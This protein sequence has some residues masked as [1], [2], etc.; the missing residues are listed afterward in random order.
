EYLTFESHQTGEMRV[1]RRKKRLVTSQRASPELHLRARRLGRAGKKGK[2]H[3]QEK[4]HQENRRELHRHAGP[5]RSDLCVAAERR[6]HR[7]G[8]KN[9]TAGF[10]PE[11]DGRRCASRPKTRADGARATAFVVRNKPR[12]VPGRGPI[13]L[14]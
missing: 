8:A 13:R 1:S 10:D 5:H 14:P 7:G 4:S 6:F 2:S 3:E 9:F 12:P 11:S